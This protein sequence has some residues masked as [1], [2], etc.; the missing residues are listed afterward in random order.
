MPTG[1]SV[2][3]VCRGNGVVKEN[4]KEYEFVTRDPIT[5]KCLVCN[6]RGWLNARTKLPN[7]EPAS[8]ILAGDK[9]D[10]RREGLGAEKEEERPQEI[11]AS[12][13]MTA[14][15][16]REK[17][18]AT[19]SAGTSQR[20]N[21]S[22]KA[23]VN[24]ELVDTGVGYDGSREV[25]RSRGREESQGQDIPACASQHPTSCQEIPAFPPQQPTSCLSGTPVA[26]MTAGALNPRLNKVLASGKEFLIVTETEPYY[27]D[28]YQMV[29]KQEKMQ[30][31]W[32]DR[33]E[34][35]YVEVLEAQIRKYQEVINA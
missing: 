28:V 24:P 22:K 15:V 35:N 18:G 17:S 16:E 13:G 8:S 27:L 26:G 5:A 3:P 1:R 32:T 25:E 30:G 7:G 31:T 19:A 29:R 12:A 10:L 9:R 34:D 2:C 33:D 21:V 6:G 23:V 20:L 14:E 11:P 4:A